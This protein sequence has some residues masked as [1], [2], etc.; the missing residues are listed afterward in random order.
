MLIETLI[1]CVYQGTEKHGVYISILDVGTVFSEKPAKHMPI[2]RIYH[3]SLVGFRMHYALYGRHLAKEPQQIDINTE[4]IEEQ[5]KEKGKQSI[6]SLLIPRLV[7]KQI[8]IPTPTRNGQH[9]QALVCITAP[10]A[11]AHKEKQRSRHFNM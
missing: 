11:N 5:Q 7:L 3:R 2:S 1:F 4:N 9:A 6:Q 8:A 10:F